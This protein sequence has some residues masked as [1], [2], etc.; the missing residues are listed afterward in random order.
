MEIQAGLGKT[1]Y[2]CVPMAPH[3][4]WE[5]LEQYGPVTLPKHIKE[6]SH[7]ER[8]AELTAVLEVGKRT[9]SMEEKLKET[10]P[11]AKR[12]AKLVNCGS[13]YG[14][15]VQRGKWSEH[16]EFLAVS[17]SLNIWK[18]FLRQESCINRLPEMCRMSFS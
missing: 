8:E 1:Q 5:W 14:A 4:A 18:H 17:D 10:R 13:G 16:L 2:G 3:T 9:A 15:L 12:K 11:M 6:K 7:K